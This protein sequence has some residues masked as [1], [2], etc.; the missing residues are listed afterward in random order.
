[1][2]GERDGEKN[3]GLAN[4]KSIWWANRLK[5]R[6]GAE[7]V[8]QWHNFFP[9]QNKNL[10]SA[11]NLSTDCMTHP[12]IMKNNLLSL[13]STDGLA[14]STKYIQTNTQVSA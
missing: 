5:T 3:Q 10:S 12:Q 14:T 4:L 13:K 9:S 7:A 1:M 2:K 11:L 8:I 6:T